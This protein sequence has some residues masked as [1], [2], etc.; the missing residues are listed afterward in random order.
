[1]NSIMKLDSQLRRQQRSVFFNR[2]ARAGPNDVGADA[3]RRRG[4]GGAGGGCPTKL[5]AHHREES[6]AC[7]TH[8][9]KCVNASKCKK[10][11]VLPKNAPT[12]T[13]KKQFCFGGEGRRRRR[14]R[15]AFRFEPGAR[16]C[17]S[18]FRRRPPRRLLWR[19]GRQQTERGEAWRA[20]HSSSKRVCVWGGCSGVL[21]A[22]C[23]TG[24]WKGW[25]G[26]GGV[27]EIDGGKRWE[28]EGERNT[29]GVK[30]KRRRGDTPGTLRSDAP[31]HIDGNG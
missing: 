6:S 14:R 13:S 18:R 24:L 23:P 4:G 17:A 15:G 9:H 26:G 3:P 1:M 2:D 20:L 10:L 5:A 29:G 7:F 19:H 28:R 22:V 8:R 25:R 12:H 21:P 30:G 31:P 16:A 11:T 27:R